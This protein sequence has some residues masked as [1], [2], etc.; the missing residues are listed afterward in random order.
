MNKNIVI[1]EKIKQRKEITERVKKTLIER[2]RLPLAPDEISDDVPL[3]GIGLGL[4]SV[5][6]LEIVVGI[7]QEFG[8]TITDEDMQAF[9]SINTI[10]DFIIEG[11]KEYEISKIEIPK[12]LFP[13]P[14]F[15]EEYWAIRENIGLIDMSSITKLKIVGKDVQIWLDKLITGNLLSLYEGKSIYT[16]FCDE[17]GYI[18]A[19]VQILQDKEGYIV[20]SDA[21]KRET[22]LS[23]LNKHLEEGIYI[24]DMSDKFACFSVIGYNAVEI[25]KDLISEDILG[26]PYLGFL[27]DKIDNIEVLLYRFGLTGELEYRFIV[28]NEF[29]KIIWQKIV[30]SGKKYNLRICS[31]DILP[32]LMLEMKSV[33]QLRDIRP[34]TTT[35]Q[36]GLHWMIQYNKEKF[37]GKEALLLEKNRGTD[38]KLLSCIFHDECQVKENASVF[39]LDKKVGEMVN[40]SYSLTLG[41]RI[42]LMY[43]DT[44]YA[45]VGLELEVEAFDGKKRV[46]TVSAP[47]FITKSVKGIRG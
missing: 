7:E 29:A 31:S 16:C 17:N 11:K 15:E 27:Y 9:R 25:P 21:E 42:G 40:T 22:L 2:L 44:K 18:I 5:D 23:W 10:V 43:I 45:W 36:A 6:A 39:L 24:E 47:L 8:I 4:D 13:Y 37:I 41:K 3:F 46:T 1:E 19:L 38:S 30:E 28:P 33:N 34:T 26:L 35:L 12:T 32:T 14:T 20:F